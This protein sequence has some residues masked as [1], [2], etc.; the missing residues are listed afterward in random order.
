MHLDHLDYRS[1][2]SF[3]VNGCAGW[4]M[5]GLGFH[6]FHY[7]HTCDSILQRTR[8]FTISEKILDCFADHGL[9]DVG[10]DWKLKFFGGIRLVEE[11]FVPI[12]GKGN[13]TFTRVYRTSISLIRFSDIEGPD[14]AEL[15]VI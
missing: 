9:L 1:I 12:K 6:R 7:F 13:G 5:L 8:I 2:I 11:D 10:D 3:W 4:L 15:D 14:A